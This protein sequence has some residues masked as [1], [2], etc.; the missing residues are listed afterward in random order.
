MNKNN[1]CIDCNMKISRNGAERCSSCAKKGELNNNY[2]KDRSLI[3]YPL[4]FNE[5]LK[6]SIRKRDNYQ[7]QGEG[8]SMTE[9]EHLIVQGRV[10]EIHHIDYNKKNCNENNLITLC[11]SCNLR[12]NYNRDYWKSYYQEVI[13]VSQLS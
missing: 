4:E 11:L 2:V 12:A 13:N 5:N 1:H 10:L 7:C 8:C 6:E 9:E 3:D